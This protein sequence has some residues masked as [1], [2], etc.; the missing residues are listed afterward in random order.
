MKYRKLDPLGDYTLGTGQDFYK[1]V[2][3]AVGQA[4]L[5]R[6]KLFKGEWFIDTTDGTPWFQDVLGKYTQRTYDAVVRLRIL[7]TPGVRA[8]TSFSSQYDGATRTLVQSSSIDTIYGETTVTFT[9]S[10]PA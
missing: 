6:L 2:P 10:T 5:T 3:A 8:I 7:Q 1:N 9:T 4:V